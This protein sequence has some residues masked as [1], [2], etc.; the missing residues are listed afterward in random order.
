MQVRI[1]DAA[2]AQLDCE[3][4]GT[5]LFENAPQPFPE[6]AVSLASAIGRN[7]ESKDLPTGV[8]ELTPLLEAP[9]IRAGG[10]LFVG[11]GPEA[12]FGPGVAYTAGYALAKRLASRPRTKVG[13]VVPLTRG[14]DAASA[15]VKGLIAGATSP[16][17]YKRE[18]RRHPI[19]ELW[20]A[21]A[22]EGML[23]RHDLATL[24]ERAVVV[25]E[26][27]QV[28]RDLVNRGPFDKPPTVL[29]AR[30]AELAAAVGLSVDVWDAARLRDERFGGLLGVAAGSDEPPA[31]IQLRWNC[32]EG[33]PA[34]LAIVGKGVTFDSGGLSIKPSASMEDMKC[35]M[36]GA[37]AAVGA[38]MAAARLRSPA[39][40][41]A[42]LPLTEN[43]PG[44]RA[45]K[46][47][48]VLTMRNG[49]TVEVLNTDAEGRLILADALALATEQAPGR[50][51]DLATL[52]GACMVALGTKVAGLFSNDDDLAADLLASATQAG[53]RAWR[54]PLDDDYREAL[55]S[56]VADLKNV[57]GKWGGSITAAKFLQEFVDGRPWAHLD[58][59]G[60]S[61]SESDS[62]AQDAGGTGCFVRTLVRLIERIGA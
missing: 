52:T 23:V 62:P 8:G 24:V 5:G 50:I 45:M 57:G 26:A 43:M 53:E 30:I 16:G 46:L 60:P 15:F 48:D 27:I 37:A 6:M 18:P 17:L 38:M 22:S 29:A 55:N 35:D 31:F 47:G 54:M 1:A 28:A 25:G 2:P 10:V 56:Q 61:W 58:I 12:S 39:S 41:A 14:T 34:D 36:A 49:K 11:L 33:R 42:Y 3:W 4:L 13:V 51:V 59:A 7:L 9:G 19:E 20:L 44:P 32:P 40:I 21:P